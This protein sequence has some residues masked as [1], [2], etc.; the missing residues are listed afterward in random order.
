LIGLKLEGPVKVN[1]KVTNLRN[2]A[3]NDYTLLQRILFFSGYTTWSLGLGDTK[4]MKK[5]KEDIKAKKKA[6]KKK[7]TKTKTK[8]PKFNL[9]GI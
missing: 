2:A 5:I 7:K 8:K 3:D 9:T 6:E 1:Q 4:K